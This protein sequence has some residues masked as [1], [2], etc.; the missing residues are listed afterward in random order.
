[1]NTIEDDGE[2]ASER[3]SALRSKPAVQAVEAVSM[4]DKHE[5]R[6]HNMM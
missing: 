3:K 4:A 1:M 6:E 2:S 5:Q